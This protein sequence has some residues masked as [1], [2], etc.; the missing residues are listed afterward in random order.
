MKLSRFVSVFGGVLLAA[1]SAGAQAQQGTLAALE[2]QTPKNGM[3]KQY[4][5]GRKTKA[6]WHKQQKDPLPLFVW[7]ILS[8]DHTGTYVVG[9]LG[10]HWADLDKPAVPDKADLEAYEKTVAPYVQSLVTRYYSQMPKVS[11]MPAGM[12]GPSK[13]AEVITY[14]IR[15]GSD[16]EFR[17]ALSRTDE[18]IKKTKWPTNYEWYEL[19]NGGRDGTFVLVIPH[20]N[21][22]DFEDKPDMKPF[23]DM[24]KEAFGPTEAESIIRRFDASV[25]STSS[26]IIEFRADLSYL[27]AK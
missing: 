11:N 20:A 26:E 22:A 14:V 5:D 2:F 3:V 9:R 16:S 25:E 23:R 4:E 17:S 21:W 18:A 15:S 19:A 27:P 10:Q 24:L 12:T 13:Y 8:G 6:D 7:E 1:A